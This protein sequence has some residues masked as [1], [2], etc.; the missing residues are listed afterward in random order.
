MKDFIDE[1]I[2]DITIV[3]SLLLITVL[4]GIIVTAA[5]KCLVFEFD[6]LTGTSRDEEGNFEERHIDGGRFK[7]YAE[8]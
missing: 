8:K 6:G 7:F 5:E 3:S 2:S 1:H 4:T